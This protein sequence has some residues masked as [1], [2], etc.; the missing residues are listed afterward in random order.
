[1]RMMS[2]KRGMMGAIIALLVVAALVAGGIYWFLY[3]RTAKE[4]AFNV[5]ALLPRSSRV[6]VLLN[7]AGQFDPIKVME[8]AKKF[9]GLLS[10]D[11]KAA[12]KKAFQEQFGFD[13]EELTK[14]FHGKAALAVLDLDG[15][16]GLVALAGLEDTAKFEEMFSK[17][18]P[19]ETGK[20]TVSGV[21]FSVQP[22]GVLVGH[23]DEFAYVADSQASA[24]ALLAAVKGGD[25]LASDPLFQEARTKVDRSGSLAAVFVNIKD[26]L[27]ALKAAKIPYTDEGT[28]KGLSCMEYAVAN[29]DYKSGWSHGFLKVAADDSSLSK[30]LLAKGGVN[31]TSFGGINKSSSTAYCFDLEWFFNVVVSFMAQFPETRQAAAAAPMGLVMMNPFA[32]Y[33]GELVVSI[34]A[35]D[36]SGEIFEADFGRAGA[37]SKRI[38]CSSN[39]KNI[40]TALEMYATDHQGRYPAKLSEL[41]P[42]YLKSIPECPAAGSDSYSATYKHSDKPYTF[43]VAC[44]G[45]HH[46]QGADLPS[47]SSETGIDRG[48]PLPAA[49]TPVPPSGAMTA[50]VKDLGVAHSL[51]VKALGEGAGAAPVEGKDKQYPIPNGELYIKAGQPPRLCFGFGQRAKE[52]LDTQ[53]GSM[54]DIDRLK[55][56][57]STGQDSVVYADY[58]T[59]KPMAENLKKLAAK[60]DSPPGLKAMAASFDSVDMECSSC[61]FVEPDGLRLTSHGIGGSMAVMGGVAAAILVP[62]FIRAR[63]QG[64][65][66]ACKSNLKNIGTGLEMWAVD[67]GGK[68]PDSLSKLT[69]E[70]LK[71]IPEC[72][73]AGK[74]TYTLQT[75]PKAPL[76]DKHYA[77]YYYLECTGHAHEAA[78]LPA[79]YPKYTAIEGLIDGH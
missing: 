64:Q 37:A 44:Q 12:Q 8:Q 15:K 75:G 32:A 19:K 61:V 67:H 31:L 58:L 62:N 5:A 2:N 18:A 60:P 9:E 49:P 45:D 56:V 13:P 77:D 23:D 72:P 68:Y 73:A 27:P 30:N 38:A 35:L 42:A 33:D 41:A 4:S 46:G 28:Y 40:A 59:F 55:E 16:P 6:V 11:E 3:G 78:G 70:Y 14:V 66:T 57:L 53:N 34:D 48:D 52:M 43:T 29:W 69:P 51:M 36:H 63:A 65:A 21:E 1:M 76:N 22:K 54:A 24:E 7:S 50:T 47:Y 25:N 20:K 10:A 39:L 26:S 74:V 79:D 17:L 71:Y